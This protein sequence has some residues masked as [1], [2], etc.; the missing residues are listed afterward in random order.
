MATEKRFEDGTQS[1]D[2]PLFQDFLKYLNENGQIY[3]TWKCF[4]QQKG[5][6]LICHFVWPTYFYSD[7]QMERMSDSGLIINDNLNHN[8]HVNPGKAN[9]STTDYIKTSSLKPISI[10]VIYAWYKL[11][12]EKFPINSFGLTTFGVVL[13]LDGKLY[14]DK[15]KSFS[16]SPSFSSSSSS[17]PS[18]KSE[19]KRED[20][21]EDE[22]HS[23]TSLY[24]RQKKR[25]L[26]SSGSFSKSSTFS[27]EGEP[28]LMERIF[29]S[30]PPPMAAATSSSFSLRKNEKE[31]YDDDN[32][33]EEKNKMDR[34]Y[35][36]I[37]NNNN[38]FY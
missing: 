12:S 16:A 36:D 15:L 19:I 1:S 3:F 30:S 10:D 11:A 2:D 25:K 35:H 14:Y 18:K 9:L 6:S 31:N 21:E 5:P 24:N 37:F 38:K 20:R 33:E 29:Y 32:E 13:N 7:K 23:S 8:C 22:S 17:S 26:D 34:K 27:K 28:S 4:L